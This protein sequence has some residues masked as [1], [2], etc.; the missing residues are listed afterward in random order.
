M[1]PVDVKRLKKERRRFQS[2]GYARKAR[3]KKV[4]SHVEATVN[5]EQVKGERDDALDRLQEV[6]AE[7]HRLRAREQRILRLIKLHKLPVPELTQ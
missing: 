2:R 1:S 3:M 6:Q 5:Y 4:A 7:N